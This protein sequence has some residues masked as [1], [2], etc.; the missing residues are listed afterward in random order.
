MK[1]L[2]L[3][4]TIFHF[5][6]TMAAQLPETDIWL[7]DV[8]EENGK[9]KF[10]EPVNVTKRKGYDNQPAF[11]PDGKYILYT[12]IRDS[13]QSDIYK[14][15]ITTKQTSQFTNTPTSEYSPT[16][17]P[18]GKGISVVMVEKDSSQRLW[19]FPLKGG[20]P[21][22]IMDMDSIGY[23]CWFNKNKLGVFVLTKPFTLQL[24]DKKTGQIRVLDDSIGRCIR[25][26]GSMMYYSTKGAGDKK[27]LNV[28]NYPGLHTSRLFEMPGEDFAM[29]NG[30]VITT[31]GSKL[32]ICQ[33]NGKWVEMANLS[34]KGIDNLGRIAISPDGSKMA[35]VTT[36]K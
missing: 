31:S 7:L 12:S 16:F 17:M 30:L 11:S 21:Q 13:S 22:R 19:R 23:H 29:R 34:S 5:T 35:L 10:G 4:L 32:F 20:K 2:L 8:S 9:F 3:T 28:F 15:D 27:Y 36:S 26:R 1:Q 24:V 33:M 14:Y 6:L 25:M 18:D